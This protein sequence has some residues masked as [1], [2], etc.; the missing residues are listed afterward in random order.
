VTAEFLVC[1]IKLRHVVRVVDD[2]NAG[3]NAG[4]VS[5]TWCHTAASKCW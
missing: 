5:A 2:A 3:A 4:A 1:V